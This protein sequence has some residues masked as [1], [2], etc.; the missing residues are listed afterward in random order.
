MGAGTCTQPIKS[1]CDAFYKPSA[2]IRDVFEGKRFKYGNMR[3]N[4]SF[5]PCQMGYLPDQE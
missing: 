3:Y 4:E 5:Y 2:S 1:I